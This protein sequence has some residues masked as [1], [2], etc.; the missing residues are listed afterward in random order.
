MDWESP[1]PDFRYVL[2]DRTDPEKNIYRY[3]VIAWLPTLFDERAVIR[4]YGRKRMT[5]R[6]LITP[7][8]SLK[9]AWPFIRSVIKTRLRHGYRIVE[10]EAYVEG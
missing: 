3:Y 5:Q 10:P 1:P 8:P 7:F 6:T 9:E 2:F 4:R